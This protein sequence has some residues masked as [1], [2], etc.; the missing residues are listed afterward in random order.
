MRREGPAAQGWAARWTPVHRR[1]G[2]GRDE[3]RGDLWS[4]GLREAV[5]E[6]LK[7]LQSRDLGG[8]WPSYMERP[9]P[10]ARVLWGTVETPGSG[11]PTARLLF[12]GLTA[13]P[14]A[15]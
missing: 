10:A 5:G 2:P 4:Q 6:P 9:A 13:Q 12:R 14:Q 7:S 15:L 3:D 11:L 1:R 8:A